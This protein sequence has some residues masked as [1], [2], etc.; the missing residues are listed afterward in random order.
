MAKKPTKKAIVLSAEEIAMQLG[1]VRTRMAADKLLDKAL[2]DALK[3]AL[4][5]EQITRAGNYKRDTSITFKVIAE[6]LALPFALERGLVKIA[7][8][9][10]HELFRRDV[11]LRF[12]DPT[13]YGFESTTSE[14]IVPIR[15]AK[16][17]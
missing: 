11:T 10:V 15:K 6:E 7:T 1:E 8:G 16:A 2:T 5:R 4:K 13:K 14:K 17:D 9:D 3:V 12:E